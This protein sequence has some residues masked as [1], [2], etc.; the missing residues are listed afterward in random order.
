MTAAVSDPE[1]TGVVQIVVRVGPKIVAV[2]GT[3]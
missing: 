3:G 2:S 1:H